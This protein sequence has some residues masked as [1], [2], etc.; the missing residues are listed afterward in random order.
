MY[1]LE[2]WDLDAADKREQHKYLLFYARNYREK[3]I[4]ETKDDPRII[5]KV[6][7][8]SITAQAIRSMQRH[9][10]IAETTCILGGV[11]FPAW[12][13]EQRMEFY[14]EMKQKKV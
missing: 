5:T 13:W 1:V 14:W 6:H 10:V 3:V 11:E 2:V 7:G 8:G 9:G 4:K 12:T